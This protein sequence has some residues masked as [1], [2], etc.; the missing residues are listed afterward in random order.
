MAPDL[1]PTQAPSKAARKSTSDLTIAEALTETRCQWCLRTGT[2]TS[3]P[4]LRAVY[5]LVSRPSFCFS[6]EEADIVELLRCGRCLSIGRAELYCS[7]ACQEAGFSVHKPKCGKVLR[8]VR[9]VPTFRPSST[10][11]DDKSLHPLRRLLLIK[12]SVF[13]NEYWGTVGGIAPTMMGYLQSPD[14]TDART[15]KIRSAMRNLAFSALR[16]SDPTSIN[17]LAAIVTSKYRRY[18]PHPAASNR[19]GASSLTPELA[20]ALGTQEQM[21]K[22]FKTMFSLDDEELEAARKKGEQE[23]K[24]PEWA[25]VKEVYVKSRKSGSVPILSTLSVS[26]AT[27]LTVSCPASTGTRSSTTTTRIWAT[28]KSRRKRRTSF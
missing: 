26:P 20:E 13:P 6:A 25:L 21:A 1:T 9:D 17:L 5:R 23:V 27:I 15:I 4:P 22:E 14:F 3:P 8:E 28:A 18:V 24:K 11:V 19:P 2:S 16:E 7:R 12:L 10:S